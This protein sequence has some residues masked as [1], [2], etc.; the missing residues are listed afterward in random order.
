MIQE[1]RPRVQVHFVN[2]DGTQQEGRTKQS[3]REQ[4]D[5]NIMMKKYQQGIPINM[6]T[7]AQPEYGDFANAD[8]YHTAANKVIQ[9]DQAFA[10]LPAEIRARFRNDPAELLEFIRDPDQEH[11]EEAIELGLVPRPEAEPA[12]VK[13]QVIGGEDPPKETE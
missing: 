4:C 11:L 3:F 2:E 12:P 8:D 10:A 1:K 7:L 9:A 5:I 6:N 13:V